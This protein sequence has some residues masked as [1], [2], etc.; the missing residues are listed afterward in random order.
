MR[1]EHPLRRQMVSEMHLRRWPE[2]AAPTLLVQIL[3]LVPGEAR[4]AEAA[5]LAGLPAGALDEADNPRHA[6]GTLAGGIRFVW[7]RH[8]E[9]SAI[10]L[11]LPMPPDPADLNSADLASADPASAAALAWAEA[12]PGEVI[13]ATRILI[14]P[15]EA[16]AEAVLPRL[17]MTDMDVVS[18]RVGPQGAA[19]IWSDFR[20][21]AGGLGCLL[22]AAG[23]V[24]GGDL[25]RLVQ[26]LQELGNYRN[27]ALLGL[28][29]AQA[30]WDD[31]NRIEQALAALAA[32]VALPQ[33]TDDMLLE[34]VSQLSL[35]LMRVA[36]AASYRMSATAAY[37]RL[38][39]ERLADVA[40]QAVRGF[41]S[42]ADFTQRRLL[43]AVRTCA[44]HVRRESE[45]SLR[46]A[47]FAAL[48]RTRIETRIENQNARLLRSMEQSATMQ[49]RLQQLVEGFSVVAL[50][51]YG[52]SLVSY[53]LKGLEEIWPGL[54]VPVI[55]MALVPVVVGGMWLGIHHL[56][57]RV[58]GGHG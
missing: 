45:L 19:R 2:L 21:G 13:R 10:T 47:R 35:D 7:E 42:L 14:V 43:P 50:S 16:G 11:F 36:T 18:C 1:F 9:A 55:D 51:Y 58:L 49:L 52:I 29:V 5:A 37:A 25:S 30:H 6:S 31:L 23:D 27:L 12:L 32:D 4:E 15:D 48:L 33:M 38:V 39:E 28:P 53:M 54:P 46:A 24:T 20:I 57:R 26:R 34:K 22:V 40:P 3:R 17:G 44:A 56:K 8:S 41:P